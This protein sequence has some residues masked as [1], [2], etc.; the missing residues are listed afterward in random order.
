MSANRFCMVAI[1]NLRVRL[2]AVNRRRTEAAAK[3]PNRKIAEAPIYS[4]PR[5]IERLASF[6]CWS[7]RGEDTC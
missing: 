4:E 1:G 7:A 5:T 6:F 2:R 3:V